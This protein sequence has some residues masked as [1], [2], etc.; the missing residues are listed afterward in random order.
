MCDL[1][2]HIQYSGLKWSR[3]LSKQI[4][5]QYQLM[6]Y[7]ANSSN[8]YQSNVNTLQLQY[9]SKSLIINGYSE[10]YLGL[11]FLAY[12]FPF[13]RTASVACCLLYLV[14]IYIGAITLYYSIWQHSIR[15]KPVFITLNVHQSW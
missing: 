10:L 6:Q 13:G 5:E 3:R 2:V 15:F 4:E 8:K 1:N 7:S 14:L 9:N 11:H 12:P